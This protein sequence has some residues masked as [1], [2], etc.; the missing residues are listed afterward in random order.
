M[1]WNTVSE[2]LREILLELS[3]NHSFEKFTLVGGTALSLQ[4]GHRQSEDIDLFT[5]EIYG[6]VDMNSLA[7]I[8]ENKY[9]FY[10]ANIGIPKTL[11]FSC[12]VGQTQENAVKLDLFYTDCFVYK[13][14]H[15]DGVKLAS[16]EEIIAMKLEVVAHG[17]RKKDFWDLHYF[18]ERY[19]FEQLFQIYEKRY[20][21]GCDSKSLKLK[22]IDFDLAD[23]D[24]DPK[25]HLNKSWELIKLDFLRTFGA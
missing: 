18:L 25:C 14:Q 1:Y 3:S 13:V 16:L 4:I 12:Y 7:E 22:L 23:A 24:F 10:R 21:Y 8:L 9:P 2:P 19:S 5:D 6:S 20:P 15:I 11:G 17:G